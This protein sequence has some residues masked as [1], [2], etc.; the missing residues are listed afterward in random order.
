MH[1]SLSSSHWREQTCDRV[2]QSNLVKRRVLLLHKK[3]PA[4]V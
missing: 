1:H 3:D 4:Y 2:A